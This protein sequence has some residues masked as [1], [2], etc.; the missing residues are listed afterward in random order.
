[1]KQETEEL[2]MSG[3][4]RGLRACADWL[5]LTPNVPLPYDPKLQIF[6]VNTKEDIA[7]LARKM[8]KCDKVFSNEMFSVVKHFGPFKVQGVAY[9]AQ[10]CERVVVGYETVEIPAQPAKP[11]ETLARE[12]VEWKCG[13]LMT[14]VEVQKELAAAP[15]L[16]TESEE[17]PF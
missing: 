17:V 5:E 3:L 16:L 8:G 11:A 14:T 2:T 9:R 6:S 4:I 15:L 1:M 12:I 7:A 13:S 10:V